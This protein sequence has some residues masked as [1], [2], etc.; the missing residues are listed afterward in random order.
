MCC[1]RTCA[2]LPARV[3][4]A[5]LSPKQNYATIE[6]PAGGGACSVADCCDATCK[7]KS[8]ACGPGFVKSATYGTTVCA[9]TAATCVDICCERTCTHTDHSATVCA[10]IGVRTFQ[11]KRRSAEIACSTGRST[12]Q[13]LADKCDNQLC[14]DLTRVPR[15]VN[16]VRATLPHT[17][18]SC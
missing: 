15:D 14:C 10:A 2:S 6:C 11:L 4:G 18:V 7:S 3:C 8:V 5:D 16:T 9:G 12:T 1:K 17:L 13:G